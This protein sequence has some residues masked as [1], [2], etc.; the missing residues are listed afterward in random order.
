MYLLDQEVWG[1]YHCIN[2]CVLRA[3]LCGADQLTGKSFEHRRAWIRSRLVFLAGEFAID[4]L[5]D[6]VL[7]NH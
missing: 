2:R 5:G 6:T 4:V 7:S 1:I 3:F